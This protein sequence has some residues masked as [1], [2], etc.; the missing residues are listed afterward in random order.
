MDVRRAE[1]VAPDGGRNPSR[2]SGVGQE[3]SPEVYPG[4]E[5]R[6]AL[7]GGWNAGRLTQRC[8]AIMASKRASARTST[9][10]EGPKE[11][12]KWRA[13]RDVRPCRRLPGFT[14]KN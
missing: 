11:K 3:V 14:S 4:A 12:R 10:S 13:K 7:P 2:V 6:A 9:S 5:A 1:A 8:A